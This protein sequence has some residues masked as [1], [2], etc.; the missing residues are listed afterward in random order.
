[1]KGASLEYNQQQNELLLDLNPADFDGE[2]KSA[3]VLTFV[4]QSEYANLYL[5]DTE[6]KATC[7][8]AKG[9]SGQ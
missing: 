2:L 8:K 7:E 4:N 3:D 6:I 5:S 9:C 1:M